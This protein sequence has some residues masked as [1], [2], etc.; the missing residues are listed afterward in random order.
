MKLRIR[1]VL[2]IGLALFAM[3]FGAGNVIFPPFL[4]MQ[5]APDWFIAIFAY[6]AVDIIIAVFAIIV[7]AKN[8]EGLIGIT[9]RIGKIP[10]HILGATIILCM[11]P[12]ICIPR[13]AAVSFDLLMVPLFNLPNNGW[14]QLVFSFF[15]F[16]IT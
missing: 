1:D 12:L 2:T 16:V 3:F 10:S 7:M 8:D 13:C 15:F 5:T 9:Q 4:G 11:G 14:E 6:L